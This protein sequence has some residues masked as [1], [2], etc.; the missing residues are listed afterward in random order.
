MKSDLAEKRCRLSNICLNK[1]GYTLIEL[2][3]ALSVLAVVSAVSVT[4]YN[5]YIDDA[6]KVVRKTN[7]RLVNE[8]LDRYY[9]E[10]MTYPQYHWLQDSPD[11]IN[12]KR[13]KGLDTE[14]SGY[15]VNKKV[16]EILSEGSDVRGNVVYFRVTESLKR[17]SGPGN[18]DNSFNEGTWMMAK[19]LRIV[20]KEY[21]V[22]EIRITESDEAITANN[23]GAGERFNFPLLADN[24]IPLDNE[25]T[26]PDDEQLDIKMVCC[27]AGTFKMG[28]VP[29]ELG[30]RGNENQ[31]M[32][33][34]TKSF[35]I[36]RYEITQKQY[37]KVMG[38]N[39]SSRKTTNPKFPEETDPDLLPVDSVTYANAVL[40]CQKL[41]ENYS[42]LVPNGYKF[43]LPT[44]AQWEYACRAGTETSLNNNF[45]I[46]RKTGFCD[47][48]DKV[49][50]FKG[51][52]SGSTHIVGLRDPN[53]W[54][55]YDM[56]GNVEELL[57]DTRPAT[58]PAYLF[59]YD[60]PPAVEIDPIV[61]VGG[62]QCY[63]GGAYTIEPERCRSAS[64]QGTTLNRKVNTVG[65]RVVLVQ[66]D[67]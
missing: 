61:T 29:G 12:T 67:D 10:H 8:A 9:K 2:F 40:F 30:A 55:I 4:Y 57:K 24:N 33:T 1:K 37:K 53:A 6:K 11:D 54:G 32:V 46:T 36:S 14:L 38:N 65:F 52:A 28:A 13:N 27:P 66:T 41:N 18:I 63:R 60:V 58:Y 64:R 17:D 43:D 26:I 59:Q 21:L 39:P 48:L 23:F 35:L 3:I 42:R 31:H 56:H 51:N 16:S 7:E 15:F 20:H 44:E 62:E 25:N 5:D 34:L 50:W 45:N 47:K 22:H 19:N 49:A